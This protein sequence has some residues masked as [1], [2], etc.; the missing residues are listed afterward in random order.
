MEKTRTIE[1]IVKQQN[2]VTVQPWYISGKISFDLEK[3]SYFS[4][5]LAEAV[6]DGKIYEGYEHVRNNGNTEFEKAKAYTLYYPL[7]ANNVTKKRVRHE[8]FKVKQKVPK[9]YREMIKNSIKQLSTSEMTIT[10]N[11]D[12]LPVE[13][14]LYDTIDKKW[15]VFAKYSYPY[16]NR[17]AY[18]KY[19]NDCIE[20]VL[21]GDFG[22]D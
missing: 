10:Y 8:N 5:R 22:E 21:N 18:E 3:K 1:S 16:K 6:K 9:K 11:K 15:M 17:Q 12:Y 13:V 2:F 4:I 19:L 7:I 14:R 20:S